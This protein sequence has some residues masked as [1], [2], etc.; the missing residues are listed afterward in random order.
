[1]LR[2]PGARIAAF[3]PSGHIDRNFPYWNHWPVAQLPNDGRKGTR[4]DRPAHTSL[5]WFCDPPVREEGILFTWTYLYGLT[6]ATATD[7]APLSKSWNS[8]AALTLA[9]DGFKSSGYDTCQRAYVLEANTAGSPP[10][11][12]V[13]LAAS[14]SSPVVNPAFV[15]KGWGEEIPRITLNGKSLARDANCR[16]GL[17]HELEGTNLVVWLKHQTSTPLTIKFSCKN[18]NP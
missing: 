13:T 2:L 11:L 16:I 14:D 18:P 3:P 12:E 10:P 8:P 17:H 4:T 15:V 7:L 5:A 6:A 1:M 9:G